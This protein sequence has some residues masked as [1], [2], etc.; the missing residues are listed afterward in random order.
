[1]ENMIEMQKDVFLCF[2]DYEKAFD[3][4]RHVDLMEMLLNIGVDGR[5]LRLVKNLYWRQ[6]AAVRVGESESKWQTIERGV[7]QGCVM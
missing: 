1:M 5:D 6:R 3:R 4:V 7:R 2:V